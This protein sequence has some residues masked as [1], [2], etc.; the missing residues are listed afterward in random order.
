MT[1]ANGVPKCF[2]RTNQCTPCTLRAKELTRQSLG[3]YPFVARPVPSSYT[4]PFVNC[5]SLIKS[6]SE[7]RISER[8]QDE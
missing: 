8:E 5:F 2:V 4:G 6:A 1:L 3:E 7:Q